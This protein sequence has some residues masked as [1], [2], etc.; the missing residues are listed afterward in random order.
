VDHFL[1]D[2]VIVV[3]RGRGGRLLAE[4][5]AHRRGTRPRSAMVIL[6]DGNSASASE[7]VVGALQDHDRAVVLGETT[8]GKGSV[9]NV[10]EL[11]DGSGLKL[12]VA[13]YYTPSGRCIHDSGID[14]DVTLEPMPPRP[15]GNQGG[16]DPQIEAAR[17]HL[18]RM[19]AE[20]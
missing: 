4:E 15:P 9:Q 19:I 5:R 7:I 6:V 11:P 18:L 12:T 20:E 1:G 14:P 8:Y 10:I 16:P 3:T 13:R 2:G 17:R